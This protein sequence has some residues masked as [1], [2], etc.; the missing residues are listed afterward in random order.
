MSRSFGKCKC[1]GSAL[2][3]EQH[4]HPGVPPIF[5]HHPL[6]RASSLRC[7]LCRSIMRTTTRRLCLAPSRQSSRS[8]GFAAPV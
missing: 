6:K 2:A 3:G 7:L 8:D 1:E 5:V 4:Q